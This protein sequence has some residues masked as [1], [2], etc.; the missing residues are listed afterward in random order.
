[1]RPEDVQVRAVEGS[2]RVRVGSRC[3]V[4]QYGHWFCQQL[5][6]RQEV[7]FDEEEGTDGELW[8]TTAHVGFGGRS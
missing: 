1:M 5:F 7:I 2:M 6:P 4:V 3:T 8:M